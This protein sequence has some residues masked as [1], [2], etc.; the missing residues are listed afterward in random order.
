ME[1]PPWDTEW[2]RWSESVA[3]TFRANCNAVHDERTDLM[4]QRAFS[5]GTVTY[6]QAVSFCSSSEADG[7]TDWRVPTQVE[8]FS[9]V[10]HTLRDPA[11]DLNHFPS[12]RALEVWTATESGSYQRVVD[13][14]TGAVR[15]RLPSS[16]TYAVC[17]RDRTCTNTDGGPAPDLQELPGSVGGGACYTSWDDREWVQWDDVERSTLSATCETV[18]DHHA[19]LMWTRLA[20]PAVTHAVAVTTCEGLVL[21]GHDDWVLPTRAELMTTVSLTLSEPAVDLNV[22]PATEPASFWTAT[23]RDGTRVWR[24]ELDDGAWTPQYTSNTGG[25]RCVRHVPRGGSGAPL[26]VCTDPPDVEWANAPAVD[27]VFTVNGPVITDEVTGLEW[28]NTVGTS[29][30]DNAAGL[31]AALD[32]GDAN[33]WRVPTRIELFTIVDHTQQSP[34]VALGAFADTASAQYW[35]ATLNPR[36]SAQ[37]LAIN[38]SNGAS[39]QQ[40]RTSVY[41]VRCVR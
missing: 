31:C 33:G 14:D 18:T 22:F 30:F 10:D 23:A 19:G 39:T 5:D 13:L 8:L 36:N 1:P 40:S 27:G 6:A 21:E 17:V 37:G 25:V 2:S 28:S 4:W 16:G 15:N 34:A 32:T 3:T 41:N 9:L 26:P 35:T 12:A 29:T 7:Y 24:V 38:F 20:L 11:L